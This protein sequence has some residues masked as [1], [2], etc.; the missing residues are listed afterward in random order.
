[1]TEPVHPLPALPDVLPLFPLS[2]V[3]LLPGGRLPLNVFEPRYLTLVEDALG[4]GRMIG[5]VQPSSDQASPQPLFQVGC[6]GRIVS[7]SETEDGRFLLTLFGVCRFRL[8]EEQISP[9]PYRTVAV[10]WQDFLA[11]R[12]PPESPAYDRERLLSVLRPY[13]K[14]HGVN[15]DW[16]ALQVTPAEELIASLAMV[17]PLPPNEKQAL[18]E[19]PSL[20]A[21]AD[22]LLTLLEMACLSQDGEEGARH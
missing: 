19:A 17:C 4:R 13:F 14:A 8:G 7:F 11:D 10:H 22:L 1:M 20:L 21:R 16:A 15:A 5:I 3:I 9:A 6:A 12:H 18:L 2:S